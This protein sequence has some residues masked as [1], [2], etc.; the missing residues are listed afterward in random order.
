M[1]IDVR[2]RQFH[3]VANRP[4]LVALAAARV[5]RLPIEQVDDADDACYAPWPE[6][7]SR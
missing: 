7:H 4:I 3:G 6:N 2:A 5:N 1:S